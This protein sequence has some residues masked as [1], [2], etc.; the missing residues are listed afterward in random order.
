MGHS[1][2]LFEFPAW[3]GSRVG[4]R[5]LSVEREIAPIHSLLQRRIPRME[6]WTWQ[7]WGRALAMH[8]DQV[9]DML[10][11]GTSI[12]VIAKTTGL[13]R[14]TVYRV[15]DDPAWAQGVLATWAA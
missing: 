15:K 4:P 6:T 13:S 8:L 7:E 10:A 1:S 12:S 3:A 14:Q 2:L 5:R 9:G 11:S